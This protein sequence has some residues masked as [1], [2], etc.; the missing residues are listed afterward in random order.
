MGGGQWVFESSE[1]TTLLGRT[2][3]SAGEVDERK[4]QQN[5]HRLF[6]SYF[7]VPESSGSLVPGRCTE[8][9]RHA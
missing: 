5:S 9:V 8:G 4:P 7:L 2:L 1:P 3:F 6:F